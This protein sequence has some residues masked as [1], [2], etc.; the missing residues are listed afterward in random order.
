MLALPDIHEDLCLTTMPM[1]IISIMTLLND[2][3]NQR[4]RNRN[5]D[6]PTFIQI[7]CSNFSDGP[8][9]SGWITRFT[10]EPWS[11][12]NPRISESVSMMLKTGIYI[13]VPA[14]HHAVDERPS[15][16]EKL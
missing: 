5:R 10:I 9:H 1:Q 14:A 13:S 3:L 7:G 16:L 15:M 12:V 6:N 2:I 4:A 11:E 8:M